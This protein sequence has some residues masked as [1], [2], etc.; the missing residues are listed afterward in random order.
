M[1]KYARE[2]THYLLYIFD[3]MR[4][5][6]ISAS[7]TEVDGVPN[8]LCSAVKR[9][10]RRCADYV[11][12]ADLY[13][14]ISLEAASAAKL[15]LFAGANRVFAALYEWRDRIARDEDESFAVCASKPSD[16]QKSQTIRLLPL[17]AAARVRQS[18]ELVR[19]ILM[20]LCA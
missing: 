5:E 12:K 1:T 18:T 19:I 10:W 8:L 7:T 16:D 14:V 15:A 6:L 4:R 17:G 11:R 3:C 9:E 20:K 2:D 13:A